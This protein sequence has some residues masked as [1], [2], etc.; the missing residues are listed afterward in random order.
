MSSP[1][2]CCF[3][4]LFVCSFVCVEEI[5][6]C[7]PVVRV[8]LI[9][10]ISTTVPETLRSPVRS[11][12]NT[13]YSTRSSSSFLRSLRSCPL[14]REELLPLAIGDSCESTSDIN[15]GYIFRW[16]YIFR[17]VY[18]SSTTHS[19]SGTSNDIECFFQLRS[20]DRAEI[21]GLKTCNPYLP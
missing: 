2:P 21:V 1:S 20:S 3:V 16:L 10:C 15:A 4:C 18:S 14:R 13:W 6:P 11:Y 9:V 5:V 12:L 17:W 19:I 8:R 7:R